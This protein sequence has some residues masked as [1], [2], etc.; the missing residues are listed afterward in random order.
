MGEAPTLSALL[1]DAERVLGDAG[2]DT[3]RLDAEVLLGAAAQTNRAGLY[4]RLRDPVHDDIAERF[5]DLV[6]RR[7]Q[8]EPV[9][10][11]LGSKEFFG[12]DFAVNPSVLIPRPET[13]LLVEIA[14]E[15]LAQRDAAKICDVGTGSGCIAV[16]LARALPAA[17]IV[18]SDVSQSALRV[19]H[20][21]AQAHGVAGRISFVEGDLLEMLAGRFD[22]IVSNP[23]Y[24]RQ[25]E[26][27]SVP[28]LGWEPLRALEAGADGLSAIRRLVAAAPRLLADEGLLAIE[29]GATHSDDAMALAR[30]AGLQRAAVKPDL[31]GLPRVLVG[32]RVDSASR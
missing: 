20:G 2:I 12:L 27:T 22:A 14:G 5:T 23:P 30:A 11:I 4:A 24:L 8:R 7:Q 9:A 15:H 26:G 1:R 6:A 19:A 32:Y 31:A 17:T 18:A 13:E 3:A 25:G 29:I 10:Y 16:A 21:N 28:E